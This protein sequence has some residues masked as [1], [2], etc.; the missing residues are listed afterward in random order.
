MNLRIV[1]YVEVVYRYN[2]ETT[3]FLIIPDIGELSENRP[4]SHQP[5]KSSHGQ[6]ALVIGTWTLVIVGTGRGDL[7]LHHLS[8]LGVPR[9]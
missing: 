4:L 9:S 3:N 6:T 2:I 7:R 5:A 1:A 8:T